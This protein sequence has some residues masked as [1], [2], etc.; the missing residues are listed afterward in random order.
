MPTP[1]LHELLRRLQTSDPAATISSDDLLWVP[2]D[3]AMP[4]TIATS[5]RDLAIAVPALGE[6]ARDALWPDATIDDAGFNLLLVHLDEV[7]A[8]RRVDGSVLINATGVVW[9]PTS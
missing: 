3:G 5:E 8:T 1:Y 4:I 9:P 6:D 2:R 7:L